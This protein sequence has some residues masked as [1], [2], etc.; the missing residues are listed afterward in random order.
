[1]QT[2]VQDGRG[3]SVKAEATKVHLAAESGRPLGC[4]FQL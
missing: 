3:V 1:M 4:P 2:V